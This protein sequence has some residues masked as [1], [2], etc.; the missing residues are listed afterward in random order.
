MTR[1]DHQWKRVSEKYANYCV[2]EQGHVKNAKTGRILKHGINKAGYHLVKLSTNGKK[3]S[4]YV[5]T[6]VLTL[7]EGACPAGY[8]CDHKTRNKDN[9]TIENLRWVPRCKNQRNRKLQ[10]NN[11]SGLRGVTP[12]KNKWRAQLHSQGR[13]VL[14]RSYTSKREAALMYIGALHQIDPED[15]HNAQ[16]EFDEFFAEDTA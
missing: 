14:D 12:A 5:H 2:S 1:V 16:M 8:E 11:S 10:R 6:L 7:F 3:C 15:A 4:Y 9:N 13:S